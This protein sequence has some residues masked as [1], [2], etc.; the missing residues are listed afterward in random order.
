MCLGAT[1]RLVQTKFLCRAGTLTVSLVEYDCSNHMHVTVAAVIICKCMLSE[2][3][4]LILS[5]QKPAQGL[6]HLTAL[7][8]GH[9]V[10]RLS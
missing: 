2:T 6:M 9:V 8:S 5:I 10:S 1:P 3:R 4:K 7:V